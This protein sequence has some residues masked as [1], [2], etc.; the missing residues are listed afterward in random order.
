MV[1]Q[2]IPFLIFDASAGAGKTYNLVKQYLRICLQ[3]NYPG[4]YQRILAI[5]F[6]NKA[7]NEMKERIIYALQHFSSYPQL[8]KFESLFNDLKAETGLEEKELVH[9]SG[10]ILRSILHAYSA[11][12]VSTID[13]FT[14]RLIRSFSNELRISGNYEVE[15]DAPAILK[16]AIDRFLNSLHPGDVA[17]ISLIKFI[18]DQLHKGRSPRVE[19]SLLTMSKQLFDERAYPY[20]QK[21]K[22]FDAAGISEIKKTLNAEIGKIK[23]KAAAKAEKIKRFL[24]DEQI[25]EDLFSGKYLPKYL[26]KTIAEGK[27]IIPNKTLQKQIEGLQGFYPQAKKKI[28]GPVIDPVEDGLR[29]L[30]NKFFQWVWDQFPF[31][32]LASSILKD[33]HALAVIA[34]IENELEEIKQ[35]TNR[36]PIGE[37]NKIISDYL[38]EQPAAFIYEKAGERYN[39]YFID[40]FQDTSVLQWKNM[41]P[42]IN[43]AISSGG[44]ALIVGDAKQAIYRWRGGEVN[45]LLNLSN[46]SDLSNKLINGRLQS[47][48]Y[49]RK[50]ISLTDNYRSRKN[51]VEFNNSFFELSAKELLSEQHRDLFGRAA[52]NIKGEDGGYVNVERLIYEQDN[53]EAYQEAQCERCLQIVNDAIQNR[54]YQ[55]RDI[56]I[57]TRKKSEATTLS[58]YLIENGINV[59]SEQSLMLDQSAEVRAILSFFKVVLRPDDYRGRIDFA[60][61][62][63]NKAS[64]VYPEKHTFLREITKATYPQLQS[65]LD[66][67]LPDFSLTTFPY[68]SLLDKVYLLMQ[69]L[70]MNH[71][72][73]P[74]L[75][76]L[77]DKAWEFDLKGEGSE[78]AFLCWWEEGGDQTA[79]SL[80]DE[81]KALKM[82]T[83]HKAKGLEFPMAILPFA[84]WQATRGTDNSAWLELDINDFGG[85]SA[86]KVRLTENDPDNSS[87][88]IDIT[89]TDKNYQQAYQINKENIYLDNLNLLYVALTR[90]ENE[91]HVIS[92]KG[93][94]DDKE[95]I[96]LYFDKYLRNIG[97]EGESWEKGKPL[98]VNHEMVQ[99]ETGLERS[100]DSVLWEEKLAVSYGTPLNWQEAEARS[101]GS[102]LH[103]ILAFIK[104][105]VDI[106]KAIERAVMRGIIEVEEREEIEKPINSV[107]Y[108]SDLQ[109]Y[110]NSEAEVLNERDMLNPLSSKN[111]P[112]RIVIRGNR[113]DVID[114]KYGQEQERHKEQVEKYMQNLVSMGYEQGDRVLVY[115]GEEVKVEKW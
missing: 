51:I 104:S 30:M 101:R 56:A 98:Y 66:G 42:L 50:S 46:D 112:D 13:K 21:L 40:E 111:R 22:G 3:G 7:A 33:I 99:Q 108:N 69:K 88:K 68:R 5:T 2:K 84:D 78:A 41:V 8:G 80:P 94:R 82:M 60:E 110:F 62:L 25:N 10:K 81:L 106:N 77:L 97:V 64:S 1:Q 34:E 87:S 76:A 89:V 91:L 12:S 58:S 14:N 63:W 103:E 49:Q 43:N 95:R 53:P 45:L 52:Q 19:E 38:Q 54:G 29:S 71:Q 26:D 61:Y 67:L 70:Q 36:I 23:E 28:A 16:E 65:L 93:R 59:V 57:L 31:Y 83:I 44:S 105:P 18:E 27:L 32:H 75:L 90:A 100:Y 107:L 37:F 109:D 102:V 55:L 86:A 15:L 85:L 39:H 11:F 115:M 47:E 79:I 96:S 9:R 72:Q 92:S 73:N 113:V 48:L 4:T 20:L 74:Y 6:T 114:Y 17:T 24:E 35:Q